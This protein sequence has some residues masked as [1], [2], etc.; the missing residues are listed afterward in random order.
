M[1]SFFVVPF[2][3]FV[4]DAWGKR[5]SWL[6]LCSVLLATCHFT[7]GLSTMSPIPSMIGLGLSY[8]IQ[9]VVLWPSLAIAVQHKEQQIEDEERIT[10][11]NSRLPP[12]KLLGMAFGLSMAALNTALTIVPLISAQ[13]RIIG[14]SFVPVELFYATLG[15]FI[16]LVLF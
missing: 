9:G 14:K 4:V 12:V 1:V 11:P 3:G 5:I 10:F 13:I 2:F 6:L 15:N 8:A 7:M 16:T